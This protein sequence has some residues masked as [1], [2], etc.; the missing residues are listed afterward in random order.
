[1]IN[2]NFCICTVITLAPC[3]RLFNWDLQPSLW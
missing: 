2:C 1:M 3:D